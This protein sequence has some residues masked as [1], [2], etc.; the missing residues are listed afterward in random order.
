MRRLGN[1][2]TRRLY[3][4]AT[5]RRNDSEMKRLDNSVTR[6]L[7][8]SA[9]R[10]LGHLG[11]DV[12]ATW[13]D[14]TTWRLGYETTR[15]KGDDACP[16]RNNVSEC[17]C[18]FKHLSRALHTHTFIFKTFHG[19]FS[20]KSIFLF[21][22]QEN[23]LWVNWSQRMIL[24]HYLHRIL[25]SSC[26]QDHQCCQTRALVA[27]VCLAFLLVVVCCRASVSFFSRRLTLMRNFFWIIFISEY[28][29]SL[30]RRHCT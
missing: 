11:W 15:W 12:S 5:R 20:S 8:G 24:L 23:A 19:L 1:S 9:K 13:D 25:P 28:E 2:M 17:V 3:N 7:G 6:R 4:L 22:K 26:C 14:Q 18:D 30:N 10:Q 16:W 27:I 21:S 29:Y